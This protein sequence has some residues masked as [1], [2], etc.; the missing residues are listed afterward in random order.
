MYKW[1]LIHNEGLI[2][3]LSGLNIPERIIR[4]IGW[5]EDTAAEYPSISDVTFTLN[6]EKSNYSENIFIYEEEK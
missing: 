4:R 5:A 6:R 2:Q 3:E 1:V